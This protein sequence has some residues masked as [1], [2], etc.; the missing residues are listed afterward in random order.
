MAVE[1]IL[2]GRN[3]AL[4]LRVRGRVPFRR[5]ALPA[6]GLHPVA[7]LGIFILPTVRVA[8]S[9]PD[10][11]STMREPQVQ[12]EGAAP[13]AV[14]LAENRRAPAPTDLAHAPAELAHAPAE[15]L[16]RSLPLNR[17]YLLRRASRF[18]FRQLTEEPELVRLR[19]ERRVSAPFTG[20][21]PLSRNGRS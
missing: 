7:T 9:S 15:P 13:S 10:K 21:P 3:V 12:R 14:T 5:D 17:S 18:P 16:D 20:I 19:R 4:T 6:E 2:S 8:G 1:E 11:R